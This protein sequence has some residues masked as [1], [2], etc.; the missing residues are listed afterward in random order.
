[1]TLILPTV[2]RDLPTNKPGRVRH[3]YDQIGLMLNSKGRLGV[4][5]G[6][7]FNFYEHVYRDDEAGLRAN[8]KA[9]KPADKFQIWRTYEMSDHLPKWLEL[10][11]K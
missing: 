10:V 6:G 5:K 9:K 4:G 3:P 8:S 11:V 1:M 2:I 7:V